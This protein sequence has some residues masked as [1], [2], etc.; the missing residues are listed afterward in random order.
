MDF[1]FD[2]TMFQPQEGISHTY[3]GNLGEIIAAAESGNSDSMSDDIRPSFIFG[4]D[5]RVL[6]PDAT[7]FPF[8]SVVSIHVPADGGGY[9]MGSGAL[10]DEY[11]VLTVAHIAYID[12]NDGWSTSM[13]IVP[14]RD[15]SNEPFGVATAETIR[16]PGEWIA[17][18]D[19]R[20]DWALITLNEPIGN[21]T[22]WMGVA[23]FDEDDSV[24]TDTVYTAGYPGDLNSGWRM[25]NTTDLG[26]GA[27]YYTHDFALDTA[28]GQSGS[29]IWMENA[30]GEYIITILAY[31]IDGG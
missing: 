27:D 1:E 24:Y 10:I 5:D 11:H 20:Y 23:T 19:Y 8:S 28:G 22:G 2:S 12:E 9:Y 21:L 14:A 3:S 13:E 29:A 7:V 25:Y 31:E 16:V 26:K 30:T 4:P 17:S 15:Y 6:V 18:E